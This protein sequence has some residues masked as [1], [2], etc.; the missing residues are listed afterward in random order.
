MEG[1]GASSPSGGGISE[2]MR[3]EVC[4]KRESLMGEDREGRRGF[5]GLFGEGGNEVHQNDCG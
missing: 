5:E 1:A 2:M 4:P 3:R